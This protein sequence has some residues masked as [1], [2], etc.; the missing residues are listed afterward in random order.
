MTTDYFAFI[1]PSCQVELTGV[2]VTAELAR[3]Q[4][5][6][7]CHK[8]GELFQF[9]MGKCMFQNNIQKVDSAKII[10][11]ALT[12]AYPRLT[13]AANSGHEYFQAAPCLP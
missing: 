12:S 11:S 5:R 6:A 13:S 1:C 3:Y 7:N 9:K 2:T 8:C 4:A 10:S